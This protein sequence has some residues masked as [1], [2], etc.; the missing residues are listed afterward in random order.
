MNVFIEEAELLC[1]LM[2]TMGKPITRL[3][4]ILSPPDRLGIHAVNGCV[5]VCKP[6][7]QKKKEGR[8]IG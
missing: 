1:E 2:R 6:E 4:A 5:Y 8:R 7:R 3:C